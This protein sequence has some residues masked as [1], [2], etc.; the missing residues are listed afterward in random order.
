[1]ARG[2]EPIRV[3]I[4]RRRDVRCSVPGCKAFAYR[5]GNLC[6]LHTDRAKKY[7]DPAMS[8]K[9]ME[10]RHY[11]RERAEVRAFLKRHA[12]HTAVEAG[13]AWISTWMYS[14]DP[15]GDAVNQHIS[16]LRDAGVKPLDILIEVA[17]MFLYVQRYPFIEDGTALTFAMSSAVLHLAPLP[18]TASWKSPRGVSWKR[19][20][21]RSLRVVGE[22]IRTALAPL[23][24]NI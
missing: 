17:A 4:T 18:T 10:R 6:S 14:G 5:I 1:M 7:G 13:L 2:Y 22:T 3:A 23:L 24:L 12:N 16:R 19:A 8:R 21:G 11:R 20:T 9:L 15:T